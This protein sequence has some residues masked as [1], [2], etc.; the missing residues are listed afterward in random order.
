MIVERPY[1]LCP[2][3]LSAVHDGCPRPSRQSPGHYLAMC[4]A[5]ALPAAER[6]LHC[7][8]SFVDE[9]VWQAAYRAGRAQRADDAVTRIA[10]RESRSGS[11]LVLRAARR[12]DRCLIGIL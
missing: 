3:G 9:S 1:R 8:P 6:V 2:F 12:V 7:R 10:H 4:G 5:D 11:K